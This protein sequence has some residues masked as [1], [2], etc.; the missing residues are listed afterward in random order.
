[1]IDGRDNTDLKRGEQLIEEGEY[2]TARELLRRRAVE[3]PGNFILDLIKVAEFCDTIQFRSRLVEKHRECL[4]VLV[5]ELE[6]LLD[7]HHP[8]VA[9]RRANDL[10]SRQGWTPREELRI[11]H[12]RLAA[13][14]LSGDADH[15]DEDLLYVWHFFCSQELYSVKALRDC[16]KTVGSI[17]HPIFMNALS[18]IEQALAKPGSSINRDSSTLVNVI[19]L[20]IRELEY[21]HLWA[22]GSEER[23]GSPAEFS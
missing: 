13:S 5:D 4:D 2:S 12:R 9:F 14:I 17:T 7:T 22:R 11:R 16:L 19:H 6:R 8:D 3:A 20:K 15:F 10:M 18:K 23:K 1:M 21:S